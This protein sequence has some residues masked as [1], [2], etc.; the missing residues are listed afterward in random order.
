MAFLDTIRSATAA[1]ATQIVPLLAELGYP[2]TRD[3]VV[4]RLERLRRTD[5]AV[6]FVAER[7][8]EIVGIATC[9]LFDAI[10]T[11]PLVA[12][13]TALVVGADQQGGGVG[14]ELVG[15]V[16]QWAREKGAVKISLSSGEQRAGAHAFYRRCGYESSGVRL[17][18]V[19]AAQ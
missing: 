3:E 19:L 4:S 7:Q 13:L 8:N 1:D 16:E 2:S 11:S 6:V 15:A 9:H 17:T 14:R 18:K 12:W 5:H 10:H